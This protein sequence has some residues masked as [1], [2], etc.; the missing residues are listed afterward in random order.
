VN[1]SDTIFLGDGVNNPITVVNASSGVNLSIASVST[2]SA[3]ASLITLNQICNFNAASGTTT[4]ATA[5][6]NGDVPAQV[7]GYLKVQVGGSAM[8]VPY[9]NP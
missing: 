5:G 6:T 2:I 3:S 8:R 4:S 7:V 9:Y 1:T